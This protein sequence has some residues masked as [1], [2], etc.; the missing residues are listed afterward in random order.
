MRQTL[1]L[2]ILPTNAASGC[3]FLRHEGADHGVAVSLRK[4][5]PPRGLWVTYR[6]ISAWQR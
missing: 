4:H 1:W 5:S 2:H 3:G 6:E